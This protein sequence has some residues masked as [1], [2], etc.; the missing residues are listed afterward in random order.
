MK[1]HPV[2]SVG[3]LVIMVVVAALGSQ[4]RRRLLVLE[5]AEK[6]AAETPPR[7]VL[8]ELGLKDAKPTSWS[9]RAVV[10]GA[11]IAHREG[12][13]F[14]ATDKLIQSDG[15]QASSHRP[16]RLPKG[17][18]ALI[19]MTG[20][21]TV[22]VV[23][24]LTNVKADATLTLHSQEREPAVV[25]LKGVL[26][27]KPQ[28]FWQ[29]TARVRLISTATAVVT[30][31]TEDDFPAAAYGP[32]GTLWVA[33]ISYTV[34]EES[35][36]IEAPDLKEQPANFKAYNT[37]EFG[38]QLLVKYYKD[39]KW[40]K[41]IA[42]TG[43]SEDIVRCAVAA[44]GDGTVWVIYSA[45]RNGNHRLYARPI[46][47]NSGG[48]RTAGSEQMLPAPPIP[49]K[50]LA[51]IACT[52]VSGTVRVTYSQWS[53]GDHMM[54]AMFRCKKGKWEDEGIEFGY[55][56]SNWHPANSAGPEGEVL[57]VYDCYRAGDYDI[58][59]YFFGPNTS[60]GNNPLITSAH[61]EARPSVAYDASGRAWIAY[62]QGPEKWGKNFGA[63]D[64]QDGNPLYF[65]RT[66]GVVCLENDKL[67]KPVAELPPLA[68]RMGSPDTGMK[69][70]AM[71]RYAYPKIGIDGKGRVWLTYR[72]KFGTRYS[73]HPGAYW[74]TFARRLDGDHWTEPIEIHHSDGL[75]DDR[76]VLLPHRAGGLRIIHTTDGRYTT[77]ETIDNQIYMSYV[78]LPG[79]PVEPR[80]VPYQ[81]EPKP[82]KL[83]ALAKKELEAVDRIKKYRVKSA[84]KQYRLLRGEF[85]RHT[86]ISWDG[87]PDGSLEDMFRYAI[88][89]AGLDWIGNGDHDNGAGR[90]YTWWLTQKFTDAYHVPGRFTPMF[91]YER[92]VSYPHGH[93]NCIFARR[94]I[95]TLPR[96]AEHD[97]KK[98]VAGIHAD[99][100][101]MLYRY[102]K[103]L[104]GIC[105]S[106]TS[107]TGMGTDWRDHDREVEP[108]VE[109]YQGDRMSY[110][111]ESGPRAGYDPKSGKLPVNI[112]GWYPKG[113]V[114]LALQKGHRLGFQASSDHMST[115]ISY[116]IVLSERHDRESILDGLKKR[117]C[118]AATD[119][120]ILDVQSGK[121]VMGDEFTTT[122][123]PALKIHVSGTDRLAKVEVLKDSQVVH[124]Y[125]PGKAEFDGRWTDP[126][127]AA[128]VHYYYVRV[129]QANGEVAWGSPMW[130]ELAK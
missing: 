6:A 86:E 8:I 108:I 56:K 124:A 118:Y 62:E 7:A 71:P 58:V 43:P 119:D 68:P 126:N 65:T 40:S 130:I 14:R 94:G 30:D 17:N 57:Q 20:I 95:R 73:T 116:C 128:G 117:H 83:V 103:E 54:L 21:D 49:G 23:L 53:E 66:I 99:D 19:K 85:H 9:G 112:A 35:R 92:S 75:L 125:E 93:R 13:R 24:H 2:L 63:L 100:T 22:G 33:Y 79:E 81:P 3:A 61:F 45:Q 41:P 101:K 48:E 120:I 96:L 88:D 70:E 84:G 12:Y 16:I 122:E 27:G 64:D 10:S 76:P 97:P 51:A 111:I 105:A 115:H 32:D 37:P 44:E 38:D 74:L 26:A 55:G 46:K 47:R 39:G 5:W 31:K 78:D 82:G 72:Q 77:P 90:E 89:A 28:D 80:L 34:K 50:H 129:Q 60:R 91:S 102:L 113:F 98:R 11:T 106:H 52:D 109:I 110:E 42:I 59:S 121:H 29:G 4:E 104:D 18:P 107:A 127:A 69:A 36:R 15:W 114:N 25:S 67:F 87:G 1:R 123:A